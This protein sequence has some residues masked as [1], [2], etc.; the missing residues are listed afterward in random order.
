MKTAILIHGWGG[1]PKKDW[2]SWAT[3]NVAK[4]GYDVICPEMPETDKPKI[5]L[6]VNKLKKILNETNE[7]IVLVGHSIGCQT[8]LRALSEIDVKSNIKRIILVAPWWFLT[9]GESE[10]IIAKP[11]YEQNIDF[12]KINNNYKDIVCIFSDNDP[13]VPLDLN[14]DFFVEKIN[15]KILLHKGMGHFS[16]DDDPPFKEIPFLLEYLK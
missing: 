5:S 3:D 2:F 10:E 8:I 7:E 6:W 14:K 4:I 16:G 15:P 1:S 11:W 13:V 12:S 9:I